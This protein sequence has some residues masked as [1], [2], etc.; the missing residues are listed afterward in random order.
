MSFIETPRFPDYI[1]AQAVAG[2]SFMTEVVELASGFEQRNAAWDQARMRFD[3]PMPLQDA[4]K[5]ELL[6][7]VRAMKGRAH[8]FRLKDWSDYQAVRE[9]ANARMH[10]RLLEVLASGAY[11]SASANGTGVPAYQLVK[12][13]VTGSLEDARLIR[14]P[15][16]GSV[17]VYRGGALAT[18]GGGAGQYALDTTT[19]RVTWV[20]SQSANVNAVSIGAS[21]Q[22]TLASAIGLAIGGRL[23][24]TGLTGTVSTVLNN[25]AH[26]IT[27]VSGAIYTISTSTTGL[28]YTSSGQGHRY[29]QPTE[30]LEWACEFDVPARFDGDW[31]GIVAEAPNFYRLQSVGLV[32]IRV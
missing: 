7:W 1:G 24:L 21:T 20:S 9:S 16:S 10:G 22:V 12:R 23:Y 4:R 6:A 2:P 19:G 17:G 15:V 3:L 32:E 27:N 18:A 13:Y 26:P 31:L 28:A 11:G 5:D 25:L 30:A 8:G 29:P 14:K